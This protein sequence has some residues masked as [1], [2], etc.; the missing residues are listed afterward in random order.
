MS[1]IITHV[2]FPSFLGKPRHIHN[3]RHTIC[4][5]AIAYGG[6]NSAIAH[7]T[8]LYQLVMGLSDCQIF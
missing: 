1:S 7:L 2:T 4:R 6:R 5:F 8:F 3:T